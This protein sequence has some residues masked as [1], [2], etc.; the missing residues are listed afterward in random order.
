VNAAIS[1]DLQRILS[2]N[3]LYEV[4]EVDGELVYVLDDDGER[5]PICNLSEIDLEPI[6]LCGENAACE[7]S[8]ARNI[9]ASI[10]ETN[11]D[12]LF[13]PL[14]SIDEKSGTLKET[15]YRPYNEV[16]SGYTYFEAGDILF[17]KVTPSMEN[18]N[19]IIVPN[20]GE[21]KIGFASTELN[22]IRSKTEIFNKYIW[23]ILRTDS[24]RKEAKR[25]M[26]GTGGLLRVPKSFF[27]EKEIFIPKA[28]R[29]N[30]K[31]YST[32][33][34]QQS[35]VAQVEEKFSPINAKIRT[36]RN[37][38]KLLETSKEKILQ[39]TFK[40]RDSSSNGSFA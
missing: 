21:N 2:E 25:T 34:L 4:E 17:A 7:L 11:Q 27:Y 26:K 23:Y 40:T 13:V 1:S 38:Q 9:P 20:Y 22:T 36:I 37:M 31:V 8:P 15:I 18:G 24:F 33:A 6:K 35:I 29:I 16:S 30:G 3:T 14:S 12:V 10:I 32:L 28:S 39:D 19:C 5:I